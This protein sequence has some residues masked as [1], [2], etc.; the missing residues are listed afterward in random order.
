MSHISKQEL[1]SRR[2]LERKE[3]IFHF[4]RQLNPVTS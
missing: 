3:A 2:I 4:Q 1:I